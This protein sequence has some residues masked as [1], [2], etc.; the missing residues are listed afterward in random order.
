ML[1]ESQKHHWLRIAAIILMSFIVAFLAFYIAME[2]M[3]HKVTDPVYNAKRIEKIMQ[4]QEKNFEKY[5][6]R[7]NNNPFVPTMR[8][9]LVN[10]VKE[11]NEY[12]VIVDLKPLEGN[13]KGIDV[14]IKDNV[15]YISG[16]I[17]KKT[18]SGEKIV[19]FAQA[20]YLDEKL[21]TDNI[22]KEK[23]GDKYIITIPFED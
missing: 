14:N 9:M 18:F 3:L 4:T 21:L 19:S 15:I 1:D 12:K 17:D 5:E 8:P 22:T 20:Y 23:K 11:S 10:L 6:D 16:E 13:E 7:M 2:M